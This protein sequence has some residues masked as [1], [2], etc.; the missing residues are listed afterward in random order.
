MKTPCTCTP[1]NKDKYCDNVHPF[2]CEECEGYGKV[3]ETLS[4]GCCSD[5]VDC[6][7]CDG[8]GNDHDSD[9]YK[10]WEAAN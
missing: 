9:A 5:Y 10:A 7:Y 3:T 6:G 8:S 1:D 4:C 2:D